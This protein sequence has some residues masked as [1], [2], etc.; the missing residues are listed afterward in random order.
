[1]N[2]GHKYFL[3]IINFYYCMCMFDAHVLYKGGYVGIYM[4]VGTCV[5]ANGQIFGL[6]SLHR[7]F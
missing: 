3:F 4:Y 7:K 5:E 2:L 1:M 6:S